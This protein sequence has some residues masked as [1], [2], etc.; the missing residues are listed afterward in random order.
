MHA[1]ELRSAQPGLENTAPADVSD[2]EPLGFAALESAARTCP[3]A[4]RNSKWLLGRASVP[5][6]RP[7]WLL[8]RGPVPTERAKWPLGLAPVPPERSKWLLW[9]AL[10]PPERSKPQHL[11]MFPTSSPL[12]LAG[13]LESAALARSASVGRSKLTPRARLALFGRA[14]FVARGHFGFVG[15]SESAARC[16]FC[17]GAR[18][19][20]SSPLRLRLGG[21]IGRSS[22]PSPMGALEVIVQTCSAPLVR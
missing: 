20:R 16:C 9:H 6:E 5:P 12:G 21:R 3:G 14:R 13:A 10:A 8:G 22:S 18:V 4:T 1:P 19:G 15:A 11:P 7:K 17:W 2:F